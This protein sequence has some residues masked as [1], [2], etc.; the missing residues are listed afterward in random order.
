M[1][2]D[3]TDTERLKRIVDDS[4][5][6][7]SFIAEKMGISYQ[8]YHKKESGQSEFLASEIAVLQDLLNLSIKDVGEIFLLLK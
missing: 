4:G 3:M 8:G 2:T 7:R 5:L 6:K 1:R